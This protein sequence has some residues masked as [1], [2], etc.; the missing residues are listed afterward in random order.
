MTLNNESISAL[1]SMLYNMA[2]DSLIIAHRNSEWTGLGPML[3]EDIAFSSIAQDKMGHSL[4]LFTLLQQLGEP[5]PDISAFMRNEQQFTCCHFVEYPIGGYDFSLMR[6]FLFDSAELLRYEFLEESSYEPLAKLA[7]KVRG[8]IKYH[9]FHADTWVI[10]LG[11][12]GN[13]E[14]KARMQSALNM[15]Y[16]LAL[17]IFEPRQQENLLIE[18][19]VFKGE[20]ALEHAWHERIST[21]LSKAGLTIPDRNSIEPVYGGRKGFHSEYLQPLLDEMTEVFTIDPSAEW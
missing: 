13:E 21:V 10:Q 12:Q 7:K 5:E 8:E 11:S 15:C 4:A 19:H 6:H 20:Q 16:P 17:G 9:V 18:Q 2:D 3:E 1:K 14:S